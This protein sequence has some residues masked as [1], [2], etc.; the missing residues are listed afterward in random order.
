M[1]GGSKAF[2]AFAKIFE[3]GAPQLISCGLIADT[4]T[5]VSA[6]LKL[7]AAEPT[8]AQSKLPG[9]SDVFR[10]LTNRMSAPA[11]ARICDAL[12]QRMVGCMLKAVP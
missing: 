1:N 3:T 2:S 5:S 6:Y 7:D 9:G 11:A 8:I 10:V 4:Q 12:R